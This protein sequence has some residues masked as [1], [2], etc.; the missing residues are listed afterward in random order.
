VS[1]IRKIIKAVTAGIMLVCILIW[2][3][4]EKIF[5]F[6]LWDTEIVRFLKRND[7]LFLSIVIIVW[8]IFYICLYKEQRDRSKVILHNLNLGKGKDSIP[9]P[10]FLLPLWGLHFWEWKGEYKF[11][12]SSYKLFIKEKISISITIF[13]PQKLHPIFITHSK[14]HKGRI[15]DTFVFRKGFKWI[16][17]LL[18][19]IKEEKYNRL[20]CFGDDESLMLIRDNS[21]FLEKV[22]SLIEQLIPLNAQFY[23]NRKGLTLEILHYYVTQLQEGVLHSSC[24]LVDCISSL[25][26]SNS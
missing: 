21:E 1:R 14:Y 15:P 23:I 2:V 7:F 10:R 19:R 11:K 17:L 6:A 4:V 26:I 18:S 24:E 16:E 12:N 8:L 22:V 5:Y 25:F 13:F 3:L 9:P 20:F